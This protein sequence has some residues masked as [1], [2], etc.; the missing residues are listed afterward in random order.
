MLRNFALEN[1]SLIGGLSTLLVVVITFLYIYGIPKVICYFHRWIKKTYKFSRFCNPVIQKPEVPEPLISPTE[2][3]I[4]DIKR[5]R[6]Q[7]SR[8]DHSSFYKLVEKLDIDWEKVLMCC[9]DS[10][11]EGRDQF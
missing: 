5:I 11:N 2:I 4:D 9:L 8:V 6:S 7:T 1:L 3:L 10:R